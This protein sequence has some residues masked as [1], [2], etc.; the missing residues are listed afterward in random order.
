MFAVARTV[1]WLAHAM[2]EY[3]RPTPLR[4]RAS[5]TGPLP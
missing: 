5:Y 1:G 2:E 4:L 3:A